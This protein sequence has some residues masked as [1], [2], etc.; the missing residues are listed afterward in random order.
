MGL[1]R[2]TGKPTA[3][4][5]EESTQPEINDR[6]RRETEARLANVAAD[7]EGIARRL[8]ELDEEWDIERAL[9]TNFGVV[10]LASIL[11]GA[12]VARPWFLFTG[13]AAGFM[14]EHALKGWCPPLPVLR[15]F[16]LRTAREIDQERYALKALRGDLQTAER[17]PDAKKSSENAPRPSQTPERRP[18][19]GKVLPKRPARPATG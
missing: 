18:G 2:T 5:V 14:L 12:L 10:N 4:R 8:R 9:Q 11:L 16:G 1:E 17:D 15:R 13:I 6:I 7:P 19:E 3:T